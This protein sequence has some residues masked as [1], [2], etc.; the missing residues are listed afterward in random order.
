MKARNA[1]A[2]KRRSVVE[3]EDQ[4]LILWGGCLHL[5]ESAICHKSPFFTF[6]KLQVDDPVAMKM[7]KRAKER[8][9]LQKSISTL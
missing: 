6:F 3:A 9:S 4:G 7:L 1:S 8:P 2:R 5:Q